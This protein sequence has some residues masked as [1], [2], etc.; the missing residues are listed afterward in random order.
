MTEADGYLSGTDNRSNMAAIADYSMTNIT[1]TYYTW[2]IN[3]SAN[4]YASNST[5]GVN[6]DALW[7]SSY[8]NAP[9]ATEIVIVLGGWEPTYD[10]YVGTTTTVYGNGTTAF[11][12][13]HPTQESM[14]A[15][16]MS[17]VI[18]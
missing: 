7:Y 6:P 14:A 1:E 15:N 8:P 3:A 18:T 5:T 16:V 17:V 13:A 12:Y 10:Y 4:G 11:N 9:N 2:Q